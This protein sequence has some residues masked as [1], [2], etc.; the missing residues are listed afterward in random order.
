MPVRSTL[1]LLTAVLLADPGLAA[2]RA[3]RFGWQRHQDFGPVDEA[4]PM[5]AFALGV[6]QPPP[7][8]G[9]TPVIDIEDG[10][11][12]QATM[13]GVQ[14]TR[15]GSVTVRLDGTAISASGTTPLALAVAI[16]NNLPAAFAG[17]S[18][19]LGFVRIDRAAGS[20]AA[21]SVAV[22]VERGA[23]IVRGSFPAPGTRPRIVVGFAGNELRVLIKPVG[24][25]VLSVEPAAATGA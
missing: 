16:A 5:V 1:A 14:C 21:R 24:N 19:D 6:E 8:R 3:L 15:G 11:N 25:N 2:A 9:A 20:V 22:A 12:C 13:I 18:T 17:C 4:W 10:S 7:A 23:L